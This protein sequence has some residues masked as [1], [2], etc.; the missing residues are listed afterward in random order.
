MIGSQAPDSGGGWRTLK[1]AEEIRRVAGLD[2]SK[3]D[4]A[5]GIAEASTKHGGLL[6][7]RHGWLV[8]YVWKHLAEPMGWGRF[9]YAYRYAKE[10]DHTPGGGGIAVRP[11]DTLRFGCLLLREGRWGDRQLAPGSTSCS[12]GASRPT[13]RTTPIASS[14]TSTPTAKS[15]SIPVMLFGSPAPADTRSTSCPP[16]TWSSGS[17]RTRQSV[18]GKR[19]RHPSRSGDRPRRPH[20]PGL[21][22]GD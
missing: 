6:V 21:E 8:D 10:V 14:S 4:E 13:T 20:A 1:T 18:P 2:R 15:R 7:V 11:A 3:L 17:G 16:W 5:F 19:Y 22:T 9:T 12:A